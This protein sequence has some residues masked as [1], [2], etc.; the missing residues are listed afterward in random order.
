MPAREHPV[1]VAT[2]A[3]ALSVLFVQLSVPDDGVSE[4][5]ALEPVTTLPLASST[6]TTGW[7]L[8]ATPLVELLGDVVI[9]NWVAVPGL[10]VK[11]VE[12]PVVR[13][14]LVAERL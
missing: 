9:C 7:V 13:L 12:V 2:P 8:K 6:M 11:F 10:I 14:V 3:V 4:I 5:E 1:K